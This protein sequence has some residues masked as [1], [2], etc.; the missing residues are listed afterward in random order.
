[1]QIV[2]LTESDPGEPRVAVTPESV[3]RLLRLPGAAVRVQ[4]GIGHSV[5]IAD[6]AYVEAGAT[7]AGSVADT[8]A[9]AD[10]LLRVGPPTD[11]ELA[12]LPRGC[13]RIGFLDVFRRPDDVRRLAEAGATAVSMELLPRTTLAQSMDALSS[14]HSLAGYAMVVLAADRLD[15][16]LPMMVTPS[17]TIKPATVLVI[18][19]GVAGLQA[20]ATARR[21]GAKVEA[22]DTR[23]ATREQV[24]SLGAKFVDI[25]LGGGDGGG[26]TSGG[27]A[28]ELTEEQKRRQAEGLARHVARADIVITTAAVFGRDAPRIVTA[29]MVA[30][31]RSGAVIVDYAASTGGNVAGT[32]PGEETVT[33][34]G[35]RIIGRH[36]YPGLVARDA[37]AMYASNLAAYVAAFHRG[38]VAAKADDADADAGDETHAEIEPA[39][40][41][42]AEAAAGVDEIAAGSLVTHAGEIVHPLVRERMGLPP[43]EDGAAGA[44][45]DTDANTPANTDQGDAP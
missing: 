18:G 4:A 41:A 2:S 21:L 14:Q 1:M 31:M 26:E 15:R 40:C 6:D 37:S 45:T 39:R 10:V 5:H 28:R 12:T 19:A 9:G 29:D 44:P 8:L 7:V 22:F 38:G 23:P 3:T 30:G 24:T 43:R 36:N 13:V 32:V 11:A 34:G 16:V 35:V 42:V 33:D 17:G 27:Y 25:D 20:I